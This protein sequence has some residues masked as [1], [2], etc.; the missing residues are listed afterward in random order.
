M[1]KSRKCGFL[2]D[3][4]SVL[5]VFG[6]SSQSTQTPL[7]GWHQATLPAGF[8]GDIDVAGAGPLVLVVLFGRCSGL[9]GQGA[10]GLAQQLLAFL[11]QTDQRLVRIVGASIQRS[12]SSYMR[13][14]YSVVSSPMHHISLHQGL[15]RFFLES[16]GWFLD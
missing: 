9:R 10:A 15:K 14:R 2:P 1:R 4:R 8:D 16:A 5:A 3:F 7:P 6:G 11:V 12:S 13:L